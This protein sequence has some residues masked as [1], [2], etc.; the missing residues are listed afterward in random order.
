MIHPMESVGSKVG[1]VFHR[2]LVW[3]VMLHHRRT[4]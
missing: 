4:M 1:T 3:G 2:V